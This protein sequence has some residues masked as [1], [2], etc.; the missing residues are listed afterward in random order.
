VQFQHHL[1]RRLAKIPGIVRTSTSSIL[2]LIKRSY[3]IRLPDPPAGKP[4]RRQR[5]K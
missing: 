3:T 2:E 1:R 4:A 5:R